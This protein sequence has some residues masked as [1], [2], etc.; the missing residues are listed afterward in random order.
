[1]N[2]DLGEYFIQIRQFSIEKYNTFFKIYISCA[3]FRRALY[4]LFHWNLFKSQLANKTLIRPPPENIFW[5]RLFIRLFGFSI[6]FLAIISKNRQKHFIRFLIGATFIVRNFW[7]CLVSFWLLTFWG[8]P[9]F[10]HFP[11]HIAS[12][13]CMSLGRNQNANMRSARVEFVIKIFDSQRAHS[14]SACYCR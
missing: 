9:N 6:V 4:S 5:L 14:L 2:T 10:S 8:A 3:H 1:M 12:A 7:L 13:V 11:P